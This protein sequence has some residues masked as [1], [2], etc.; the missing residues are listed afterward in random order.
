MVPTQTPEQYAFLKAWFKDR[1]ESLDDGWYRILPFWIG[2]FLAIG[3]AAAYCL[4]ERFWTLGRDNATVL[5]AAILTMNGIILALSWSAFAKIYE[6]IG[7]PNFSSFLQEHGVLEKFLF[8]VSYVHASQLVAL[9]VSGIALI[10]VQ[11][12]DI[13]LV[14]QRFALGATIGLGTYAIK[15]AAGSV[16]V[17]HQLIQYRSIFDA[18]RAARNGNVRRLRPDSDSN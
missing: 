5:Y 17:M 18:D 14:W 7:A 6:T 12:D 16:T 3:F 11:F 13:P 10:M 9:G 8:Y 15:Q 4:P 1:Q 2:C